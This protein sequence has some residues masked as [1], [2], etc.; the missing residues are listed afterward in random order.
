MQHRHDAPG[1]WKQSIGKGQST[2]QPHRNTTVRPKIATKFKEDDEIENVADEWIIA[3][4]F[5]DETWANE[6]EMTDEIAQVMCD[7]LGIPEQQQPAI[8]ATI[9][10]VT[11]THTEMITLTGQWDLLI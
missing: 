10:A 6:I 2:Q 1:G 5:G 8:K 4:D 3:G 9:N 7:Y 11:L